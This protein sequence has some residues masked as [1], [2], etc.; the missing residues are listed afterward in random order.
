MQPG[1][2]SSLGQRE[3]HSP[4]LLHNRILFPWGELTNEPQT[5]GWDVE[6]CL[7][8]GTNACNIWYKLCKL[9]T[10]PLHKLKVT[11]S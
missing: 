5:G 6:Q 9:R 7:G 3:L 10:I 4:D 8:V 2:I 1:Q 11:T